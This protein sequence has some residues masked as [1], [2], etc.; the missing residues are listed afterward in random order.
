MGTNNDGLY[1]LK[2][3]VVIRAEHPAL[4]EGLILIWPKTSSVMWVAT[5]GNGVI[6]IEGDKD[7]TIQNRT[8]PEQQ[9]GEHRA[10]LARWPNLDWHRKRTQCFIGQQYFVRKN[11]YWFSSD[12]YW[13]WWLSI[14]LAYHQPWTG[15][16]KRS[17][18]KEEIL[19]DDT[20]LP[21]VALT[22][23]AFDREEVYLLTSNRAG[24]VRERCQHH[25]LL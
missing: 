15:A 7:Q 16:L 3:T 23:L 8:R 10:R 22:S 14:H 5:N 2:D 9:R 21:A 11:H 25:N 13:G 4:R 18:W 1:T 6:G 17:L 19:S 24:L 12:R 20:G